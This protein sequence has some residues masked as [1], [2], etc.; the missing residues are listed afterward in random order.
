[1]MKIMVFTGHSLKLVFHISAN[2]PSETETCPVFFISMIKNYELREGVLTICCF[3]RFF[4]QIV[5]STY[6]IT[7]AIALKEA[8]KPGTGYL[9]PY[10]HPEVW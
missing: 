8:E 10:D 3:I 2:T 7:E 4:L 9:S 1:M 5:G 6:G